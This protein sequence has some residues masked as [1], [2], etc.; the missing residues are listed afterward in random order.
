MTRCSSYLCR[1]HGRARRARFVDE[2]RKAF[3]RIEVSSRMTGNAREEK[4]REVVGCARER[5][6]IYDMVQ[7]GVPIAL[8]VATD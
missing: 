3:E 5:S 8:E 4:L 6:T 1:R 7:N 2:P